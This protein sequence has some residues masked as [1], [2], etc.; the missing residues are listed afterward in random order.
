MTTRSKAAVPLLLILFV[1]LSCSW[2]SQPAAATRPLADG[3]RWGEQEQA[4]FGSVIVLPSSW[5]LRH[6]LPPLE[7]KQGPSCSTWDP[8]NPCP[9]KAQPLAMSRKCFEAF[10]QS[11]KV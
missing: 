10:E 1:I 4:G 7:M 8:N 9:T 2:I 11:K 6:K 5:R 3:G